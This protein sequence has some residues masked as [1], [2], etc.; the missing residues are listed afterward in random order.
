MITLK[1][2]HIKKYPLFKGREIIHDG[3]SG[4][5]FTGSQW[6]NS[7]DLNDLRQGAI[8]DI[9]K[10]KDFGRVTCGEGCCHVQDEIPFYVSDD[11]KEGIIEY[12][13]WKFNIDKILGIDVKTDESLKDGEFKLK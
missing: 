4:M 3:I 2:L 9:K 6:V 5:F 7:Y 13:K 11:N 8:E 1:D 12:I 10:I